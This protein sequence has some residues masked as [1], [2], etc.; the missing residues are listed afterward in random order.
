MGEAHGYSFSPLYKTVPEAAALDERLYEL[1][2]LLDAI[3]DGQAREAALAIEELKAQ[4]GKAKE[5]QNSNK[6]A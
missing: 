6:S 2:A 5:C 1:L 4:L 3:R